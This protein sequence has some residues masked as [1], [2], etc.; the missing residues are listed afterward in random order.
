MNTISITAAQTT[1]IDNVADALSYAVSEVIEAHWRAMT[2]LLT[3]NGPSDDRLNAIL[4]L[5]T[6]ME[7]CTAIT[8]LTEETFN[9]TA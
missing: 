3:C 6:S 2:A 9:H 7:K 5:N 8:Q 1:Q 4:A